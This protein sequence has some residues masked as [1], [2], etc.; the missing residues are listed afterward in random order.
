MHSTDELIILYP[1]DP[2]HSRLA[3]L[4]EDFIAILTS[5]GNAMVTG[6]TGRG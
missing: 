3:L 1:M 5:T 4:Q 2:L 6:I